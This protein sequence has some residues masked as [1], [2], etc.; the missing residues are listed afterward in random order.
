MLAITE[1][2]SDADTNFA[3]YLEQGGMPF[4]YSLPDDEAVIHQYLQ[5]LFNTIVL[6]DIIR[7]R[8]IRH[9]E[10]LKR[11][12][13]FLI[14]NI[15]NPYSAVSI[16]NFLK[17]EKVKVSWETVSDYLQYC[18]DAF[19]LIA[20]ERQ[21]MGGK[22]VLRLSEKIYLVDHGFKQALGG[23]QRYD[24]GHILENIVYLELLRR[25]YT[26]ASGDVGG[27][28]VDFV[29]TRG[30]E[31]RYLQVSYLLASTE[32]VEREFTPLLNIKDN[33]TKT[34]LSMDKLDFSRDGVEHRNLIEFLLE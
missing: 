6:R 9:P 16:Q 27:L 13:R 21:T 12:V 34:V 2:Q 20:A 17:S 29:A 19:F 18:K 31:K 15:G 7:D 11:I 14:A 4:T 5:D 28:E 25:G 33:Y 26:V 3:R 1:N 10:I 24:I 8:D 22:D 23:G 30:K 32:T